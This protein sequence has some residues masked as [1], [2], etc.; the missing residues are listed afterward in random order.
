MGRQVGQTSVCERLP[1]KH[2]W[3]GKQAL[4]SLRAQTGTQGS[5]CGHRSA[6]AASDASWSSKEARES[7]PQQALAGADV[8]AGESALQ[9]RPS[10][11]N[12]CGDG[13][14]KVGSPSSACSAPAGT[15]PSLP[16]CTAAAAEDAAAFLP[17]PCAC[18][19]PDCRS[20]MPP[21]LP[22]GLRLAAATAAAAGTGDACGTRRA[23]G[24]GAAKGESP[25][26][27]W[28]WCGGTVGVSPGSV[29]GREAPA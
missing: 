16:P 29:A 18:P 6:T 3:I 24:V 1:C 17:L 12:R 10:P 11:W 8:P 21:P 5:R 22:R 19:A 26:E 15:T 23:S 13:W 25:A 14:L 27:G 28:R 9:P 7:K 2:S 20:K 4:V